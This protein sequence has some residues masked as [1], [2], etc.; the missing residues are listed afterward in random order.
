MARA[1]LEPAARLLGARD[2]LFAQFGSRDDVVT[3]VF[4][5]R[6]LAD[7]RATIDADASNRREWTT[8]SRMTLEEAF[9]YAQSVVPRP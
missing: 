9:E 1:Q 2:Q 6:A 8:G 4:Y 7:L 3:G 5:D